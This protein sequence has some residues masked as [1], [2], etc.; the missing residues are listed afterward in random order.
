MTDYG[1]KYGIVFLNGIIAGHICPACME[2]RPNVAFFSVTDN[3][4]H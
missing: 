2:E 4:T 3:V 1:I